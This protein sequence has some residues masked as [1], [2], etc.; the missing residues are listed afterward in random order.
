MESVANIVV[1]A[2]THLTCAMCIHREYV[3]LTEYEYSSNIQA[4]NGNG[5][6]FT[7]PF[8]ALESFIMHANNIEVTLIFSCIPHLDG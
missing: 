5:Y 1:E 7:K 4:Q 2:E 3:F 8:L 6:K